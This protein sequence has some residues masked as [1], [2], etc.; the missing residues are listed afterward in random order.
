MSTDQTIRNTRGQPIVKYAE[1]TDMYRFAATCG[2]DA[3]A[4]FLFLKKNSKAV[5]QRVEFSDAPDPS[6]RWMMAVPNAR[7]QSAVRLFKEQKAEKEDRE[8]ERSRLEE[9]HRRTLPDRERRIAEARQLISDSRRELSGISRNTQNEVSKRRVALS[10]AHN[11]NIRSIQDSTDKAVTMLED[12]TK[13]SCELV[14]EFQEIRTVEA[15]LKGTE[16]LDT[17]N[18]NFKEAVEALPDQVHAEQITRISE[19]NLK[20]D[21]AQVL[22]DNKGVPTISIS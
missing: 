17:A 10:K 15:R 4:A 12:E 20:I 6:S 2:I 18:V 14:M 16:A 7:A 8:K 1:W 3:Y 5:F 11:E 13:A 21:Q 19:L 9:E 22:I